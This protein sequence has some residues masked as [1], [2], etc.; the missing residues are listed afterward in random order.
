[1]DIEVY[2]DGSQVSDMCWVGDVAHALV[3]ATEKAFVGNVFP[4]AVEVGPKVNRTVQEIAELIIKLSGST[5][6][7]I[8]LPMRPGEIAGAT[9][10]ANVESLKHVDMSDETLMPLDEGMQLTID[11]FREVI[12]T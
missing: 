5:S 2:G 6:K 3:V 1:M 7:I 12:N 11:H 4:E 10:S 9:V 8:N